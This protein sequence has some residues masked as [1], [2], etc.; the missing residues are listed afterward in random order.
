MPGK[1]APDA[2]FS[3]VGVMAAGTV[4]GALA[5]GLANLWT[6]FDR[7]SFDAL[8]R[9]KAI[10]VLNG[11]MERLSSLYATTGFG[12]E[13]RPDSTGYPAA[14]GLTGADARQVYGL[15][16]IAAAFT[17]SSAT[18]FNSADAAV[19]VQGSGASAR[20]HVWLD[21]ERNL[22]ARL[23]WIECEVTRSAQADCWDK[24]SSKK[25][26]K[27]KGRKDS[28]FACFAFDGSEESD[29]CRMVTLVL[30]YPF[31]INGTTVTPAGNIRTMTLSTIT[32]RRS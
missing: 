27:A 4:L 13:I 22:V 23:S 2:G 25:P 5:I 30:E 3:L 19:L 28:V 12:A 24:S 26:K 11:E 14:P 1:W 18:G 20:N 29:F 31:R 10:L 6:V 7:M 15:S 32:G 21:P 8:L 16:G 17:E 9:Q